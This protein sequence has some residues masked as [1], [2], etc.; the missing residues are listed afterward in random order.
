MSIDLL[1]T[2]IV[3]HIGACSSL[4]FLLILSD[5]L[6]R[7]TEQAKWPR[8]LVNDSAI[9]SGWESEVVAVLKKKKKKKILKP[10]WKW[11]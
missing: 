3:T 10:K 4:G 8:G 2:M 5:Q 9:S 11:F 7:T 1:V 6:N